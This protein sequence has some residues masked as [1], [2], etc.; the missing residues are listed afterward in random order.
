MKRDQVQ[1]LASAKHYLEPAAL[2][3]RLNQGSQVNGQEETVFLPVFLLYAFH[4][5]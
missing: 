3:E 2:Q 4:F 1:M 5:N